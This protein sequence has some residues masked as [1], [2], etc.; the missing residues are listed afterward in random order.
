MPIDELCLY[1][2]LQ[3]N[4]TCQRVSLCT[5]KQLA[6]CYFTYL[7]NSFAKMLLQKPNHTQLYL[8]CVESQ[9]IFEI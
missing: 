5:V 1:Y 4:N 9:I 7:T 6:S 8:F 3:N 2:Y